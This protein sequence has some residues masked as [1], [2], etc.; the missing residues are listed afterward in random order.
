MLQPLVQ[1]L[2][3]HQVCMLGG[4]DWN[5]ELLSYQLLRRVNAGLDKGPRG[6]GSF[7]QLISVKGLR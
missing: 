5:L 7:F 2:T 4:Y 3:V 1:R 6:S